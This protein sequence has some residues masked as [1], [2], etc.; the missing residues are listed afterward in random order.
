MLR[1]VTKCR[2]ASCWRQ[3]LQ[4]CLDQCFRR[5]WCRFTR[6]EVK[7][8]SSGSARETEGGRPGCCSFFHLMWNI[9]AEDVSVS[10]CGGEALIFGKSFTL[11]GVY[12]YIIYTVKYILCN[13]PHVRIMYNAHIIATQAHI[14]TYICIQVCWLI[15]FV[16]LEGPGITG[17]TSLWVSEAFS[18]LC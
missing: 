13:T 15:F 12:L 4:G 5:F 18:R 14:F 2:H 7:R 10:Q 3:G 17:Q 9:T 11:Y 6:W 16:S 1:K 8:S